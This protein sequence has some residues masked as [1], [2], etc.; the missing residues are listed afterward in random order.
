MSP[1]D[2]LIKKFNEFFQFLGIDPMLVTSL[3]IL[4]MSIYTVKDI[5]NWK[6]TSYFNKN[7]DVAIWFALFFILFR[8]IVKF[9]RGD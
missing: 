1:K 2:E 4:L 6:E 5:K 8:F 7:V 3:I 9:I